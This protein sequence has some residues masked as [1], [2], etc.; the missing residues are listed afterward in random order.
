M[1]IT[2]A[3]PKSSQPRSFRG[4]AFRPRAFSGVAMLVASSQLQSYQCC[5]TV[6]GRYFSELM[7]KSARRI[8]SVL[9]LATGH[10][11]R[12]LHIC[13]VSYDGSHR[14]SIRRNRRLASSAHRAKSIRWPRPCSNSLAVIAEIIESRS[15]PEKVVLGDL[16]GNIKAC[17]TN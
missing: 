9:L 5:R 3:L 15:T 12:R 16:W 6:R 14:V 13:S 4:S 2:C 8:I 17:R 11:R 7:E 10:T 1:Q